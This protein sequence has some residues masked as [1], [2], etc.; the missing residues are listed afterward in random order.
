MCLSFNIVLFFHAPILYFSI[1][2]FQA[3]FIVI[4]WVLILLSRCYFGVP[5]SKVWFK[6]HQ[7]CFPSI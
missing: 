2:D 4:S 6:V 1:S 5:C 3:Y 7:A